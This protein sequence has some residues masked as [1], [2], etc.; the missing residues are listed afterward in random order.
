MAAKPV[1]CIGTPVQQ[2]AL[3][4]LIREQR[5][6]LRQMAA[7]IREQRNGGGK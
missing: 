5:A 2:A 1:V 4:A 7:A 3:A 6:H